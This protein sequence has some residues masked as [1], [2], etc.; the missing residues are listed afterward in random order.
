MINPFD[1][2]LE[3]RDVLTIIDIKQRDYLKDYE[4]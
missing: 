3:I 4:V 2:G 1:F